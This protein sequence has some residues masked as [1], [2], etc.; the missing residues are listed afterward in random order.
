MIH[1]YTVMASF[2]FFFYFFFI[3]CYEINLGWAIGGVLVRTW[4]SEG[5]GH[6]AV[7]Q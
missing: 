7:C 6:R 5:G 1:F 3:F 2:L 4:S